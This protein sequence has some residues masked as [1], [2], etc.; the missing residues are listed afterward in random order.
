MA[1]IRTAQGT[2]SD[3]ASGS[4]LTIAGVTVPDGHS[5]V[6]GVSCE[7]AQ[8][9]PDTVEH[10]GKPLRRRQ[11]QDNAAQGYHT[12]AWIKGEYRKD[13]TGDIVATWG[14]AIGERAMVASSFDIRQK[15][16]DGSGSAETTPTQTPATGRT[17]ALLTAGA[18]VVGV[19]Y[20]I[21]SIGTT[22][23]TAIGATENTVGFL[24]IARGVGSG[25]GTARE[26]LSGAPSYAI[27]FFG[28]NG[29]VEDHDAATAEIQDAGVLVPATIGQKAGTTGGG[30]ASN[31]TCLE[32]Y[33]ELTARNPTRGR[34]VDAT[35]RRWSNVIL[36]LEQRGSYL[37]QGVTP[38]D[39]L[40]VEQ[41]TGLGSGGYRFEFNE[42]SGEWEAR[43]STTGALLATRSNSTGSWG[44]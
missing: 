5:L 22:D 3:K 11:Q 25:T 24:F 31:V 33:L 44:A 2:A 30:P 6:V 20:E 43:D 40:E 27:C 19:E 26:A 9:A 7:N 23:F 8:L 15:K 4:T 13:Q 10:N 32:T 14:A 37:V 35:S 41:V 16:D 36:V 39:F 34:L 21:I 12:S 18:F 38:G 17:G 28:S 42:G 1:I 29:P